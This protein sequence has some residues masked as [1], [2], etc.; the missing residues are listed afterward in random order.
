MH[1]EL[2][3]DRVLEW[4]AWLVRNG[5]ANVL[6]LVAGSQESLR[7]P[8]MATLPGPDGAMHEAPAEVLAGAQAPLTYAA[9]LSE[10]KLFFLARLARECRRSAVLLLS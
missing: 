2:T 3:C 6:V 9:S 10:K 5:R 8:A 1:F 7:H 4:L